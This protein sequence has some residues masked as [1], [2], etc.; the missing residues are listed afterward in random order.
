MRK[1]WGLT[2]KIL[3]GKKKIESRWYLNRYRPWNSIGDNDTIFFKDS[4]SPITLM[5]KVD[6]VLQFEKL[7]P[8][9]A[10]KLLHTYGNKDGIPSNM[11]KKYYEI[12]KDK[13]Y[14]ILIFLKD[15]RSIKPFDID[16]TG[17][18]NMSAWI[19]VDDIEKIKKK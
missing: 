8:G 4:G 17:F 10:S 6:H 11:I 19:T 5:A 9:K 3:S 2:Q 14:C 1:S 13:R 18:G 7:T 16:K 12:F 15:V